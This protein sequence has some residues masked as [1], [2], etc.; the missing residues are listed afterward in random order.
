[1]PVS[2]PAPPPPAAIVFAA[3]G[4]ETRLRLLGRLSREGPLP[5]SQLASGINITRQ[6][7]TKHL[8]GLENAHLVTHT[9]RG[10]ETI[11]QLEQNPLEDARRYLDEISAQWDEALERLRVLVE[12]DVES[13]T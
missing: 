2:A 4:D 12:T 9:Y 3:L 6:A 1:M 5:L 11:W 10:R 7:V 8:Q 13:P